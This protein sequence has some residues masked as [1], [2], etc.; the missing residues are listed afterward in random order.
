MGGADGLGGIEA[1]AGINASDGFNSQ[2]FY[3]P[4]TPNI[5]TFAEL[6]GFRM[7]SVEAKIYFDQTEI[8][9]KGS[10]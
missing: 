10:S 1:L 7:K 5:T 8:F 4:L 2:T 3:G 9:E 6:N